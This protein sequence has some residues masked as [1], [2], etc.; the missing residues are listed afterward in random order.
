MNKIVIKK[1]HRPQWANL[2]EAARRL[3]CSQTQVRRHITGKVPSQRL[4][5]KMKALNIEVAE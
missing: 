1:V 3:G 2:S 4:D 5:R